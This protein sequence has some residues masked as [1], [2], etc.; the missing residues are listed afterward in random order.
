MKAFQGLELIANSTQTIEQTGLHVN[1]NLKQRCLIT[2]K[3]VGVVA[4]I[5]NRSQ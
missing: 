2:L 1:N 4:T 5:E 3:M